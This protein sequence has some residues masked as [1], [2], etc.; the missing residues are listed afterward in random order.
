M[1]NL[2]RSRTADCCDKVKTNLFLE[3]PEVEIQG[4][5]LYIY[6]LNFK[7]VAMIDVNVLDVLAR[8]LGEGEKK[9]DG[10]YA[11]T[12]PFCNHYKKKLE[13]D[14]NIRPG[15]RGKW[16]CWVCHT[17]GQSLR[18]LLKK[19]NAPKSDF[20]IIGDVQPD[21]SF[22]DFSRDAP[23]N[24]APTL[25]VEYRLL[26]E[27]GIASRYSH[28]ITRLSMR[29]VTNEDII[30]Y[31]IGIITS[32]K[33]VENVVFPSYDRTGALNYYIL[34][35]FY[36]GSYINPAL[37]RDV[38]IFDL[39]VNWSEPI[40]LVE[41]VFDAL[42]IQQNAIPLLGK[43]LT[44]ALKT[45]IVKSPVRDVYVALDGGEH[46][47]INSIAEY[48][49]SVGKNAYKVNLPENEDPSSIGKDAVWEYIKTAEK[50]TTESIFL[51]NITS[52]W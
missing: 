40:I 38:V 52:R 11:Y 18:S 17:R 31:K 28:I 34:K 45:Q 22:V 47:A 4:L 16:N 1:L 23:I 10:N 50:I 12:C 20:G 48:I 25:P 42:A 6:V 9:K 29:G 14:T 19:L 21:Y 30:K 27:P 15:N 3:A 37:S 36:T 49:Q 35:D 8:H 41:G 5:F 46:E 43:T 32:G 13:V 2:K 44:K 51:Q 26:S 39:F 24:V 33:R 7:C